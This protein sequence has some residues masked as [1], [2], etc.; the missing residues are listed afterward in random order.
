[1]AVELK[2]QK[3]MA[4]L[5]FLITAIT[6]FLL[7]KRVLERQPKASK[8]TALKCFIE[9]NKGAKMP[10]KQTGKLKKTLPPLSFT[11]MVKTLMQNIKMSLNLR[12]ASVKRIFRTKD[13]KIIFQ[14]YCPSKKWEAAMQLPVVHTNGSFS[15]ILFRRRIMAAMHNV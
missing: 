8:E 9:L 10:K 12:I 14:F 1:M 3:S 2:K 4:L 11:V 5:S 6:L 13:P 15:G 7:W